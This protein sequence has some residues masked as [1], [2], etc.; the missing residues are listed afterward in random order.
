[1]CYKVYTLTC[2]MLLSGDPSH[3]A[4]V[5]NDAGLLQTPSTDANK[6][7]RF[8]AV[9]RNP[10]ALQD[11]LGPLEFVDVVKG[12]LSPAGCSS[13]DLDHILEGAQRVF[14]CLPQ[15]LSSADMVSVSKSVTDACKKAGVELMVRISSARIDAYLSNHKIPSQGPLGEAHVTGETYTKDAGIKLTSIRPTSFSTNFA[16]YDLPNIKATSTFASP[17]G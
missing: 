17:L 11:R 5:L 16:A 2:A 15:G 13:G 4:H 14:L 8:R 12:E 9:T 6:R 7:T 10:E 3:E 1:M